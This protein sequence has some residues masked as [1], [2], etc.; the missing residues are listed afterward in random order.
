MIQTSGRISPGGERHSNVKQRKEI[1]AGRECTGRNLFAKD[2]SDESAN[3]TRSREPP[4]LPSPVGP[5]TPSS[6]S[7]GQVFLTF[8]QPTEPQQSRA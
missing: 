2:V 7:F 3:I 1:K 4:C 5:D 6:P 8:L